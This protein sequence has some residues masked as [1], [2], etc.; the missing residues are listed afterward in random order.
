MSTCGEKIV[1]FGKKASYEEINFFLHAQE[2]VYH[3]LE[4]LKRADKEHQNEK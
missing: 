3:L 2:I 4:V 1:S